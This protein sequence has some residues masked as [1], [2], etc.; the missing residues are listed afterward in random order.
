MKVPDFQA[1]IDT[2]EIGHD[3]GKIMGLIWNFTRH[4]EGSPS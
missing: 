1:N 4:G 2:D 3:A